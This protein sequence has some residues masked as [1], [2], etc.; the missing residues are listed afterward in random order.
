[1]SCTTFIISRSAFPAQNLITYLHFLQKQEGYPNSV[2]SEYGPPTGGA[3]PSAPA[4][5]YGAPSPSF[6]SPTGS[7]GSY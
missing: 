4:D 2:S 3:A 1:M 7:A 6:G 5:S